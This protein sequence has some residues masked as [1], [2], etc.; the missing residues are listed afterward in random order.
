MD[1]DLEELVARASDPR[2]VPAISEYCDRRCARCR[3]NDRCFSFDVQKRAGPPG[4]D[5]GEAVAA[6]MERTLRLM[7]AF[8]EREGIK[9]NDASSGAEEADSRMELRDD[10]LVTRA[11]EYAFGALR[12]LHPLDSPST[13]AATAPD[14]RDAIDSILWLSTHIA[15]KVFRAVASLEQPFSP[16]DHP[17]QND[18]HGSA[19]VARVMIAE[20]LAAW[21]L[22]ND[23]GRAPLDSPTRQAAA[24]L[25]QVDQELAARIPRAMEFV[26]P[27]F[28]EPIPGIVRPWSLTSEDERGDRRFMV[29]SGILA[30]IGD[31]GRR[32]WRRERHDEP[33][34]ENRESENPRTEL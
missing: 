1:Q 23:E 8:A 26:R 29:G 15:S 31:F 4:Q 18:A 19:K 34:P 21:R 2:W 32:L 28:D 5:V 12:L 7:H 17:T 11:R 6:S 3:F 25:E 10:P 13:M 27:G 14:V 22:L 16:A 20:S 33:R 30:R 9:L 24:A